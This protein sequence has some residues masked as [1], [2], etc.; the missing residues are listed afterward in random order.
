M[1]VLQDLS[2]PGIPRYLGSF[3]TDDGYCIVQEYKD[4]KPLSET[5]S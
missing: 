5:R 2:H 1:Q 3:E 4:A